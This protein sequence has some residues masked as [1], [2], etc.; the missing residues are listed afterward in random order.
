M[1]N[2]LSNQSHTGGHHTEAIRESL[3]QATIQHSCRQLRMPTIAAQFAP[4][5]QAALRE[6]QSHL[7]YLEALFG[8]RSVMWT[9]E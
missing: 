3:A 9:V 2:P 4:L 6:G 1:N 8:T 5:A 7:H